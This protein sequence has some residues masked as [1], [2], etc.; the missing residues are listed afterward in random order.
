MDQEEL[1]TNGQ[2]DQ[3]YIK[4]MMGKYLENLKD[5]NVSVAR[6]L[7]F[8]NTGLMMTP[9]MM[10]TQYVA[11]YM[12]QRSQQREVVSFDPETPRVEC[13]RR[14]TRHRQGLQPRRDD[15]PTHQEPA[16]REAR[17]V[18]RKEEET[19]LEDHQVGAG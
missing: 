8:H 12:T 4:S 13:L 1:P 14:R 9:L 11:E 18:L 16:A 17:P 3:S 6:R 19:Q 10:Q 7:G 5:Q 15:R 2:F